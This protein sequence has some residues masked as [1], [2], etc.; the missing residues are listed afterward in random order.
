MVQTKVTFYKRNY[1][2]SNF[3]LFFDCT[4]CIY[5]GKVDRL[6]FI[7][8]CLLTDLP[9][10]RL[11]GWSKYHKVS[12]YWGVHCLDSLYTSY[13][14]IPFFLILI[15]C[16]FRATL[17]ANGSSNRSHSCQPTP[18]GIQATSATYTTAHSYTRSPTHWVRPRIEPA[19]HGS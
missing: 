13:I 19:S 11:R 12:K 14:L 7:C 18:R 10:L 17:V 4:G 6:L 15:F 1:L 9:L 2:R 8:R 3:S 16:F 5:T